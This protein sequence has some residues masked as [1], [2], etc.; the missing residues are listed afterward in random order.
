MFL[1]A[2]LETLCR[3]SISAFRRAGVYTFPHQSNYASGFKGPRKNASLFQRVEKSASRRK[4]FG[5]ICGV[6][7]LSRTGYSRYTVNMRKR[8]NNSTTRRPA[9]K[10]LI[11]RVDEHLSSF[12][13]LVSLADAPG[14]TAVMERARVPYKRHPLSEDEA[15][16]LICDA[17]KNE[18]VQPISK[19][20]K[21]YKHELGD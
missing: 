5:K 9:I 16:N 8:R 7:G 18:P 20:L 4:A 10:S 2:K 13:H 11:S 3:I 1:I 14:V 21:K 19:L 6:I 12:S 17:R 15:L